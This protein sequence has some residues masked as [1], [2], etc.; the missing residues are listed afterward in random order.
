MEKDV[1]AELQ[2]LLDLPDEE[3]A[4]RVVEYAERIR[5]LLPKVAPNDIAIAYKLSVLAFEMFETIEL[6]QR[7]QPF[8]KPA[9]EIDECYIL[10]AYELQKLYERY[11]ELDKMEPFSVVKYWD[12]LFED[13]W[14]TKEFYLRD[15]ENIYNNGRNGRSENQRH[16]SQLKRLCVING[17]KEPTLTKDL[18]SLVQKCEQEIERN[19]DALTK[20]E[21]TPNPE[22]QD[23]IP[24]SFSKH[25]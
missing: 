6:L 14:E 2:F 8:D 19:T 12:T 21:P 10:V 5:T 20:S 15:D 18:S 22:W 24:E 17:I 4:S 11:P 1:K 23:I 7:Q 13:G 16:L 25:R 3:T 9:T